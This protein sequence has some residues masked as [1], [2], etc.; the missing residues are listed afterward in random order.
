LTTELVGE[1]P[2]LQGVMGSYYALESKEDPAVAAA[3]K[4]HYSPVGPNDTC[5]TAPLSVAVALADKIDTL[6]G[7]FAVD[8]KPTGSRDPYAL[9]R[10]ALGVIRI[11]LEN[12]LRIPLRMLLDKAI[13]KYPK[14]MFKSEKKGQKLLP[15]GGKKA[16]RPKAKQALIITELLDF[17]ADRLRVVLKDQ[18]IG[19]DRIAAV[20]EGGNEDDLSRLVARVHALEAFLGTEDGVNVLAAYKRATNIVLVEEKK[21]QVAYSGAPEQNL[22]EAPEEQELYAS[23]SNVRPRLESK[24]KNDDFAGAMKEL[25]SLRKPIDAFFEKVVVNC[26]KPTLRKNRLLLLAQLRESLNKV[27]DFSVLEG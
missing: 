21:D 18:K 4:E 7:L 6:I 19:H 1:F 11:I 23:F 12:N 14:A 17:F 27:A 2:E 15:V 24:L 8:E 25:A 13:A 10:A 16:E 5:P 26:D 20:F 3:V 9:R 22:L